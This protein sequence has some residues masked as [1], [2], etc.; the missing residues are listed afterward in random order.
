MNDVLKIDEWLTQTNQNTPEGSQFK[1]I[2]KDR[3]KAMRLSDG[4]I[5]SVGDVVFS[6]RIIYIY[7]KDKVVYATI[8]GFSNDNIRVAICFFFNDNL[9]NIDIKINYLYLHNPTYIKY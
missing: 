1:V 3:T 8:K 4:A 6:D 9:Y 7:S 5:F 2:T